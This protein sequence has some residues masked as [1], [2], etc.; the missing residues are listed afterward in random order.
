MASYTDPKAPAKPE[1]GHSRMNT[2]DQNDTG[3][4]EQKQAKPVPILRPIFTDW[5]AF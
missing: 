1:P 3:S 5:A 4:G 2:Q